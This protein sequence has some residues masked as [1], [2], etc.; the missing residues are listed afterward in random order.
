[1]DLSHEE[2]LEAAAKGSL[3]DLAVWGKKV[4]KAYNLSKK[5]VIRESAFKDRLAF[6]A[7]HAL[8][9]NHK[10]KKGVGKVL[11]FLGVP[12]RLT[13]LSFRR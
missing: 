3:R 7:S 12:V 6:M 13:G 4:Q 11:Q 2:L 1:M 10:A 8:T 5:Q 9:L